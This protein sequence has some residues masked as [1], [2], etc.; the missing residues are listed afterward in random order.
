[1]AFDLQLWSTVSLVESLGVEGL[2]QDK[3]VPIPK[4]QIFFRGVWILRESRGAEV[5]SEAAND[6]V[7]GLCATSVRGKYVFQDAS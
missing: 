7:F 6:A 2:P 4:V 1:M 5:A 3:D